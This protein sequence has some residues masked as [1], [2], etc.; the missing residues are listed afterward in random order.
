MNQ[1]KYLV[2]ENAPDVCIGIEERMCTYDGWRPIA[3]SVSPADAIEKISRERP[4]L[5]FLDWDLNG[6][7]AYEV[8][9]HI[10][11]M[12]VYHPYIIFNTGFQKDNP[13]I[14]Q[15]IFN[16]YRVDKYIAK[17]IWETLRNHLA[18]WLLEARERYQQKTASDKNVWLCNDK[19]VKVLVNLN[20]VVCICQHNMNKRI[21]TIFVKNPEQEVKVPLSWEYIFQLLDINDVDYF[22][23]KQRA[24]LVLRQQIG[25]FDKPYV[26]FKN[27][28]HF[29]VEVVRDKVKSFEEWLMGK[30]KD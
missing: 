12:E 18:A 28:T 20:Q 11:G 2:I 14:P 4:Q 3:F 13:E 16:N 5:I 30:C 9:E 27:H 6:G 22:V 21:K 7:S 26:R 15:T 23:T 25:S 24:H 8:L 17:P 29:K 1:L 10:A 19:G